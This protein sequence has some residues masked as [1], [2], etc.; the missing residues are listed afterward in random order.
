MIYTGD[1]FPQWKGNIFA[2]GMVG[3]QLV[4]LTMDGRR[5][6]N[7]EKLAQRMGRIRDVRQGP[8]GFIYL[9]IEDRDGKPTPILRLEPVPRI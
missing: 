1:R 3:Q 9:A 7:E 2:G 6:M 8:D 4:R 5:V